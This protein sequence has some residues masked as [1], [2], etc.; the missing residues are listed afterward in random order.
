MAKLIILDHS[1]NVK[2]VQN[3]IKK[4][5]DTLTNDENTFYVEKNENNYQLKSVL[6]LNDNSKNFGDNEDASL[7]IDS[8]INFFNQYKDEVILLLMNADLQTKENWRTYSLNPKD[9][10]G[11]IQLSKKIV[12][13]VY[14]YLIMILRGKK[15][16]NKEGRE[17]IINKNNI[18]FILYGDEWSLGRASTTLS[19][20]YNKLDE[21]DKKYFTK[22][23]TIPSNIGWFEGG[24]SFNPCIDFVKSNSHYFDLEIPNDLAD[25]LK[26]TK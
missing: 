19:N 16:I 14:V 20:I 9:M 11:Q 18:N 15:V 3:D 10:Q 12:F 26:K 6:H 21:D 24:Y 13:D 5:N 23:C 7:I 2:N 17:I 22:D 8:I 1:Y 4:Y 25:A